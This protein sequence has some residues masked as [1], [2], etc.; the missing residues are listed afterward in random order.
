M[1]TKIII[2]SAADIDAQEAKQMGVCLIPMEIQFGTEDYLDG[3][4]LSATQFY[5]KLVTS[6]VLPKTSQVNP[7]RF[8]EAYEKIVGEGDEAV[9]ITISSRLSGTYASAC[10]AAQKYKGK[11]F[12]V[13]SMNACTGERLLCQ[14]ALRLLANGM[15]AE[16]LANAL[17]EVKSKIFVMAAVGTLEYLKKGGRI[18]SAVAIAGGLLSIKPIVALVDGEVKMVSKAMG[19]KKAYQGL[20]RIVQDKGGI[21]FSMPYGAMFSGTS[22]EVLEQYVKE[23]SSI[24]QGHEN[25]LP[26][27]R[28]GSTIGTHVGPGAVG[29]AFFQK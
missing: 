18:S 3:V 14:Y 22:N 1:A 17:D 24:W 10:T 9:V 27:Y 2:D 20:A 12:V 8:E 16:A 29:L 19:M 26:T 4:T 15:G 28:I 7:F 21:D 6:N 11:I 13:D 25:E 23:T 5:E